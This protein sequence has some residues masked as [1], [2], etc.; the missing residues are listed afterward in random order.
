M[1]R[2]RRSLISAQGSRNENPG[3]ATNKTDST[4]KGFSDWR[5][6]SGLERLCD[7]PQGSRNENPGYARNKTDSTLKGFGDWRTLSGLER[8]CDRP[9]GSRSSNPG[10]KLANAFGVIQTEALP[11]F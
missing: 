6:L 5:T 10:L 3:Y 2:Q 9:Q 4:L 8:L 11:F 1:K 7:R